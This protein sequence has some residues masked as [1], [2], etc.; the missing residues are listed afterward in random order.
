MNAHI[1]KCIIYSYNN[2]GHVMYATC[3]FKKQS[4]KDTFDKTK[5]MNIAEKRFNEKCQSF[6]IDS[7]NQTMSH[8]K[9]IISKIKQ[10]IY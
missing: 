2:S 8:E 7:W 9:E 4:R 1:V 6:S 10:L 5:F 3:I